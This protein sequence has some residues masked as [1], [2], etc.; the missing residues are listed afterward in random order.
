L[1]CWLCLYSGL[2]PIMKGLCGSQNQFEHGSRILTA[3]SAVDG[4]YQ[5]ARI[6]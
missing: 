2:S 3:Y 5:L 1:S 4:S 6:M